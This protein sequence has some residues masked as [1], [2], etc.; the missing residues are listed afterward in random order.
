[1][2]IPTATKIMI[3]RH[4]EKPPPSNDPAGVT[5]AGTQDPESLIVQ[6]WQRAGGLVNLFAPSRGPFQSPYLATPQTIIA[7]WKSATK[8]SQRPLQTIT[9]LA[10]MLQLTP[11]T[12]PE[13]E[14]SQAV[15][16]ALAATGTVLKPS[17]PLSPNW[18]ASLSPQE[19]IVPSEQSARV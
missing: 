12:F 4:A 1:M 19:T 18:P 14:L 7:S 17:V 5:P 16:A 2:A 15:G 9:P 10:G 11:N 3:I 8:G 13:S 6:G